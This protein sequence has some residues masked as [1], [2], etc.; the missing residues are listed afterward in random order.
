[1]LRAAAGTTEPMAGQPRDITALVDRLKSFA[2]A[3]RP[4]AMETLEVL[5]RIVDRTEAPRCAS[6]R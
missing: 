6:P 4:T 1:M 3:D 2:P 5:Q